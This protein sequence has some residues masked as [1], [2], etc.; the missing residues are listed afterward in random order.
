MSFFSQVLK[1][2]FTVSDHVE[3]VRDVAFPEYFKHQPDITGI[4]LDEQDIKRLG[5][6][7]LVIHSAIDNSANGK[8]WPRVFRHARRIAKD[9]SG[10]DSLDASDWNFL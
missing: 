10:F 9:G 4:V 1:R 5:G 3:V 7:N 6:P 8:E 2:L